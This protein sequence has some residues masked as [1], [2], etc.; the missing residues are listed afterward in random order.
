MAYL[1]P[2]VEQPVGPHVCPDA[3]ILRWERMTEHHANNEA[4]LKFAEAQL[5]ALNATHRARTKKEKRANMPDYIILRTMAERE[6]KRC[7]ENYNRS[8]GML[9]NIRKP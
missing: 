9:Q 2:T 3:D 4:A 7:L 1:F 5:A 8:Q 6:A